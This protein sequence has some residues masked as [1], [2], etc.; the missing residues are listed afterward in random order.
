V[1][2]CRKNRRRCDSDILH[3]LMAVNQNCVLF[4]VVKQTMFELSTLYQNWW[5]NEYIIM[6][7]TISLIDSIVL[8]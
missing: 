3:K 2:R 5:M 4:V 7:R 1:V 8:D 6:I